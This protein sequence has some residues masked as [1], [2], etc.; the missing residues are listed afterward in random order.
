MAAPL[1]AMLL[2]AGAYYAARLAPRVAQRVAM[3]QGGTAAASAFHTHQPYRR[4]ESSFESVMSEREALLLL[5]FSEKV[6]DA[7]FTRPSEQEVKEHYYK[8]M[9]K[10]HSDVDG[11]PFVAAKLNEARDLLI[12][13]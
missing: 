8:L 6:A 9:K 1:T 7:T 2:L 3:A 12:K 13:R 4:Y 11:S 10:L 5:G